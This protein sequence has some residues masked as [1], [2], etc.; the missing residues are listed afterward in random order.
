MTS[1]TPFYGISGGLIVYLAVLVTVFVAFVVSPA[2]L[3]GYATSNT[4]AGTDDD[5]L[6]VHAP[7]REDEVVFLYVPELGRMTVVVFPK[8]DN[9]SVTLVVSRTS[10]SL[11]PIFDPVTFDSAVRPEAVLYSYDIDVPHCVMVTVLD[12]GEGLS[13]R[14]WIAFDRDYTALRVTL[15]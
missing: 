14:Y 4:A 7:G 8:W 10:S 5:P 3:P 12:D 1:R 9:A 15:L 2:F 11:N 13:T 6:M